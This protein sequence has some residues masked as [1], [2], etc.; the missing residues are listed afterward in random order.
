MKQKLWIC[1]F[2]IFTTTSLFAQTKTVLLGQIKDKT[3]QQPLEGV[4]MVLR[5]N[6]QKTTTDKDGKFLFEHLTYTNDTLS[7]VG[8]NIINRE[9]PIVLRA[10]DTLDIGTLELIQKQPTAQ[11]FVGLIDERQLNL[12]SDEG[13]TQDISTMLI[14]SNDVFLQ[15]AGYQFSP[16]RFNPRGYD[17]RFEEKYI[18]GVNF[19]DQVR[20]VFGYSSIGALNDITRNGDAVNYFTTPTFAFGAIGGSENIN[21]RA[22]NYSRG[23]KVTLSATNRNYYARTMVSYA[24]GMQ[25]NG[26]AF[27]GLLGGRYSHEGNVEGTFYRNLSYAFGVEKQWNKGK[28]SIAFITFGSPVQRGQQGSSY[29][30]VYDLVGNN[31]YNPNWG[32]QNGKKRNARVVTAYDPTAILSHIW[33]I[34]ENSS[35]SSGIA[36]HYNRYGRTRLNW[37]NGPDPRPDYYRYLPSYYKGNKTAFDYYTY[38]WR[39]ECGTHNVSQINWDRLW[40]VNHN[41]NKQGN[42]SAVYMVEEQRKDLWEIAFNSTYNTKLNDHIK[43]TAGVGYKN[44]LAK[45]FKTVNDLLGAE[46]L[47]DI[48]K[49]AERDFP[50]DNTAIQND[51]E[52]KNRKVYKDDIFGYNFR[53]A[54]NT[55]DIWLQ[56]QHEL[57]NLDFYYGAKLKYTTFVREGKMRNG[58]Y[59]NSSYG[60]GKDHN[61]FNFETK[62]G[63]TY[64]FNGRH[65]L[66][67][68]ISYLTKAP[69]VNSFYI[70]PNITDKTSDKIKS[71]GI[72]A[73]DL[74]YVFSLP[75]ITG[76]ISLFNTHF[77]D[78]MMRISY[79]HDAERTFVNHI[80]T[81]IKKIHRGVEIG[82]NYK[83]NKNWGIEAIGT[84]GEY[85][86]ANNPMGYINY[87]NGRK[88]A[89]LEKVYMKDYH[90]G[91]IPN[92]LGSFGIS[93]FYDY[94]F[95]N[96][97]FNGAGRNYI[98]IAPLR[99]LASNYKSLTPPGTTD[100]DAE[101]YAAYEKLTSQE[102]FDEAFTMDFSVGKIWYLKNRNSLNFNLS[103]NNILND[104]NIK[105]GGYEQGRVN[106][107]YPEHFASRYFY[108]QGINAY[109]N[110]SYRF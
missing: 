102:Q 109:L 84:A 88:Q 30:E 2:L 99:R 94:W 18:N 89:V 25:D 43:L 20:G 98:K 3:T 55:A 71:V 60:R 110:I 4:L 104:K 46:Y 34:D 67:A 96:L 28:Q 72:W 50:G 64:K 11:Q 48:D 24:S 83:I 54:I 81:G 16:F 5:K 103:I 108:M 31:L 39:K 37:Y 44:S 62:A 57:K 53:Y 51:L 106:L 74:N 10:S 87:E 80:L 12:E 22:G 82:V 6:N 17:N 86:Y 63:A 29:Q 68:N 91:G 33:K 9:I 78:D 93:Y 7:I 77:Y 21:M 70:S 105:T 13:L 14:F 49:F 59:P 75:K 90:I 66:T 26:W 97:N 95:F 23:G 1:F 65:F 101:K 58:R 38:L 35:L 69:L 76:R 52:K 40:E 42:G 47:L 41:N 45:Q 15:S 85:F 61:F 73:S 19:N 36:A 79:Y 27:V 8:A 107:M 32:Y 56:Q 92:L 100:F